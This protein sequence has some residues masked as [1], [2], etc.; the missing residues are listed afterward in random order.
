MVKVG[1]NDKAQVME[2]V[3]ALAAP[4]CFRMKHF[5]AKVQI[6]CIFLGSLKIYVTDASSQQIPALKSR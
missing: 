1:A 2:Q 4:Q 3:A 5:I 6:R